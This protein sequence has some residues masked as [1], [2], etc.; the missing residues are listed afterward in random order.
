[1]D[2]FTLDAADTA[3][4]SANGISDQCRYLVFGGVCLGIPEAI[5]EG[6]H[7]ERTIRLEKRNI[8]H[9]EE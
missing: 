2:E 4:P 1:V 7:E 3:D 9:H 8:R 6:S 5:V